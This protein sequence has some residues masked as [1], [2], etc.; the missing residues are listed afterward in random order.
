MPCCYAHQV[1]NGPETLKRHLGCYF[2]CDIQRTSELEAAD[3]IVDW[4]EIP[5]EITPK[6]RIISTSPK[7]NKG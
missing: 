2:V 5:P 1:Y 3:Y 7:P 4:Q 6:N